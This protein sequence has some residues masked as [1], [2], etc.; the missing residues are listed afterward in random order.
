MA[1]NATDL[2]QGE[3]GQAVPHGAGD[4]RHGARRAAHRV[5][6]QRAHAQQQPLR[7]LAGALDRPLMTTHNIDLT[8]TNNIINV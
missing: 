6:H 3:R 7:E 5:P 8:S 4:A 2:V 1:H